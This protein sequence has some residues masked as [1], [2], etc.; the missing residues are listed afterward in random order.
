MAHVNLLPWRE[1]ARQR[2]KQKFGIQAFVALLI[3]ALLIFIAYTVIQ[4]H[5]QKQRSR[6]QFLSS[7]IAVLDAQI[8]EI[9]EINK[10]KDFI[11][12]RMKLIQSLHRDRNTA[13]QMLNELSKRTPDGV[14]IVSMEK[15]GDRLSLR[16]RSVSNN[17]VSE[18]LRAITDSTIFDNPSLREISSDTENV[19]GPTR[20]NAFSL[21]L[22]LAKPNDKAP[23]DQEDGS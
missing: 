22:T 2:A 20:Y 5:Q 4:D 7:Q 9:Q 13:I 21:S 23:A 12:N 11:V 19:E 3:A 14:H 15:R 18:F 16:G 10:K 8:V 6:N 1:L 17:R